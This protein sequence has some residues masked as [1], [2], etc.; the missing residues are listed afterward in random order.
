[1]CICIRNKVNMR[2]DRLRFFFL[3][4]E[5]DMERGFLGFSSNSDGGDGD[6]W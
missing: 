4:M 5:M 2:F 6:R 3:E 1:M